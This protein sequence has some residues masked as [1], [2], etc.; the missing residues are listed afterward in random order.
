M[1]EFSF[2]FCEPAVELAGVA[3][4]LR[5]GL[6]AGVESSTLLCEPLLSLVAVCL[7]NLSESPCAISLV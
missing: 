6:D 3:E 4:F 5:A 1:R 2:E 7:E